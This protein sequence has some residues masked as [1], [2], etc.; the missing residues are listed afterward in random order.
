M[1][2]SIRV[3]RRDMEPGQEAGT[4]AVGDSEMDTNTVALTVLQCDKCSISLYTDQFQ[5]RDPSGRP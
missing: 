5:A 4:G 1:S 3:F 2:R